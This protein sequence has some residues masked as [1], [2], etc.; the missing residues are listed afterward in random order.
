MP[1]D[2]SGY[3]LTIVILLCVVVGITYMFFG[4]DN[5][6]TPVRRV[7]ITL[8]KT[9][10]SAPAPEKPVGPSA[11]SLAA[12]TQQINTIIIQNSGIDISVSLIDLN[13]GQSEHYGVDDAFLAGS[14][15][16][17]LTAAYFLHQ[18][19]TGHESLNETINGHTAEYE[20][21]QMIVISDDTSWEAIN[22]HL[23]Y[24]N[25]Q[26]YG[27]SLGISDIEADNNLLTSGDMALVLQK[28]WGGS[29][30]NGAD[31]QLL[32]SDLKQ[33]NF[34]QFIVPAV[35]ATDTIYHK[36]G[37][38]Q[39]DV[40]DAAIITHAQKGFVIV[41]FTNGHGL[42]NWPQRAATMQGITKLALSTYFGQ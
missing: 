15:A 21:R 1:K 24:N 33:A 30:L 41:I 18:V 5:G 19:E 36:V 10:A 42:M 9:F 17:I 2:R 31:S 35:P 38:Y 34:R 3:R 25:L 14:T 11:A 20:L 13:T 7:A 12:M 28:L 22:D 37:A 40:H 4:K 6:T 8:K 32:L 26:D 23:G 39:D 27:E 29:L 16:K